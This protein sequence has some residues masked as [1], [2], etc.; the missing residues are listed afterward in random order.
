MDGSELAQRAGLDQR[1][2]AANAGKEAAVLDHGVNLAGFRRKLDQ[3]LGFRKR[4]GHRLFREHM[5]AGGKTCLDDGKAGRRDDEV[6]EKIGLQLSQHVGQ[7]GADRQAGEPMLFGAAHGHFRVE[8]DHADEAQI[9]F[10]NGNFTKRGEPAIGHSSAPRHDGGQHT[11]SPPRTPRFLRR[12]GL[13]NVYE[14][15]H[16]T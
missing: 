9:V 2:G 7:V 1:L 6:E 16:G 12:G 5:A 4:I 11:R 3:R 15:C 14:S 13:V 8:I 10:Q